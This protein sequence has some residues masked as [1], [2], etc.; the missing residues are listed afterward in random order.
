VVES[1]Y[2]NLPDTYHVKPTFFIKPPLGEK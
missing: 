2:L 1:Y